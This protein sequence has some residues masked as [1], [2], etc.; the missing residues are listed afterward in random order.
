MQPGPRE[1]ETRFLEFTLQRP[2]DW[3]YISHLLAH[4]VLTLDTGSST[5]LSGWDVA[6]T[7]TNQHIRIQTLDW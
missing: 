5:T 4:A 1:R 6:T 7:T 3:I 2:G